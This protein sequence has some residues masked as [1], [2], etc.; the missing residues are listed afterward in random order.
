M[1]NNLQIIEDIRKTLI[2]ENRELKDEE[3]LKLI[4]DYIFENH[5]KS[6]LPYKKR[7]SFIKQVFYTLRRDL[8]I[9]EEFR[10]DDSVSEIMVNGKENIFIEK[11]GLIKKTDYCFESTEALEEVIIR[12][13]AGVHRE[14]NELSPI[15]DARL[16]DGSRV[17]AVYKNVALNGPVLTIRKFPKKNITMEALIRNKTITREGADFLK[18]RVEEGYNI[19][20]SGG[21]SSGKTTFLNVLA[22]YIP[23][24]ER[25]IVIE[26]SLE[27]KI[28]NIENIVRME[29]R[30]KNQQGKGEVTMSDLIKT[31]LRMRPDR[32]IVGE[33]RGKEVLD[34]I[35]AM[36]TGHDGSLCTGHGNSIKGMLRRLEAM[37]LLA[38]PFPILAIRSQIAEAIDL[39]VH[40]KR[41]DKG[42]RKVV[43]IAELKPY[44]DGDFSLNVLFDYEMDKGLY[45]T[46]NALIKEKNK[47]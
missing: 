4:E 2:R 18:K 17:N 26:D 30:N 31:S 21:T 29:V 39:M 15:V 5:I 3:A 41:L 7:A 13:V 32:V 9:L 38:A 37:F 44:L 34:M 45:K 27:L 33:V 42:V 6:S 19:L 46:N 12:L 24:N 10:E 8:G 28:D 47:W 11:E 25:I 1:K 22:D 14:I 40:L 36:N 20:I 35:Q 43:Q 16:K 23:E